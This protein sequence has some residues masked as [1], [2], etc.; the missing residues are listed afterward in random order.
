MSSYLVFVLAVLIG[1]VAGLRAMTAPA[2]ISWAAQL[3]LLNLHGSFLSF[4]GSTPAVA[5]FTLAALGEYVNDKLPK[6]PS[7]TATPSLIAR[8]VM[9]GLAGACICASA[10]QSWFLGALL[11]AIGAMIGTF[12]GY[13]ARTG[14]VKALK[15][16]DL[17][18]ALLEDVVSIGLACFVV[19]LHTVTP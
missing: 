16:K 14:L 12:G 4:M 11:G 1:V 9:G 6:T 18:I 10:G 8:L 5:I 2:V 3:G 19:F 7:R 13:Q 15:V 17:Y